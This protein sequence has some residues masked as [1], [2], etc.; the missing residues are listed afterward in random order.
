MHL[1]QSQLTCVLTGDRH[2]ALHLPISN[3]SSLLLPEVL[4][5]RER[6]PPAGDLRRISLKGRYQT[7]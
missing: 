6:H 7:D 4:P 2:G 5:V 1:T 3:H